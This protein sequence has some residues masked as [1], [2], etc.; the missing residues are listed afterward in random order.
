V[1]IGAAIVDLRE[2]RFTMEYAVHDEGSAAL[3]AEGEALLV[4]YDYRAGRSCAIPPVV[5][6]AL[7]PLE[8]CV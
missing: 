4:Y 1:R 3:A 6:D 2:K 7:A 5:R 8:R